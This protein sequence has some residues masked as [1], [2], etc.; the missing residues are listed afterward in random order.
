M[1]VLAMGVTTPLHLA[2][3]TLGDRGRHERRSGVGREVEQM[4]PPS[5]TNWY[6]WSSCEVASVTG[7]LVG[8]S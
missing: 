6:I 2:D 4:P 7:S 1:N 5:P 8:R 3:E